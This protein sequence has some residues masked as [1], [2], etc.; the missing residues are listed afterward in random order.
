MNVQ[1]YIL[2]ISAIKSIE[3]LREMVD[4][5]YVHT[6]EMPLLIGKQEI[7]EFTAPKWI[8][9]GDIVFFYHAA[10]A[11]SYNRQLRKEIQNGNFEDSEKLLEYLDYCDDLYKKYGGKIYAF[12]SISDTPFYS[13]S[14]WEHPHFKTRIFA[15]VENVVKLD[16]PLS[17]KKFKDFLPIARQKAVTPVFGNSFMKLK[18][19][20]LQ[21]NDSDYLKKCETVAFPLKDVKKG[22][23]IE[24]ANQNG[25]K[26]LCEEQFRKYY[27]D[28][29]LMSISDDGKIYSE[30][31]C[32]K[33]EKSVGRVDNV[34]L[35]NGVYMPV[36]VKLS[37]RFDEAGLMEQLERYVSA[38]YF[39]I[40]VDSD[41][42][43]ISQGYVIFIDIFN[44]CI[45][46]NEIKNTLSIIM[47]LDNIRC[48]YDVRKLKNMFKME[49]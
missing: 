18:S 1:A 13:E 15:P 47:S 20:I 4:G 23:W 34:I 38:D 32:I 5:E 9:R 21:N 14:G 36:E 43:Q 33:D 31:E 30:V 45:Y 40:D 29:L 37:A 11:N 10:T 46:D 12:G 2:N 39:D 17:A 6:V 25:K 35:I 49:D 44:I 27:V 24:F 42:F 26:Y 28:F 3:E 19:L 41:L 16:C 7:N 22:T 48:M 8:M